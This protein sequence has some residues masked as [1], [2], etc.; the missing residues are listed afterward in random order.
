MK[1]KPEDHGITTKNDIQNKRLLP[2][3]VYLCVCV[4]EEDKTE[5]PGV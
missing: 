3:S 4:S 1:H 5:K 2:I